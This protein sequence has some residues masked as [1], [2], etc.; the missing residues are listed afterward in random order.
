MENNEIDKEI[1]FKD[2]RENLQS[3]N[4]INGEKEFTE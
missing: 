3:V 1:K 4:S 2:L